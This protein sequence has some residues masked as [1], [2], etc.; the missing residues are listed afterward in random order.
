[1]NKIYGFCQFRAHPSTVHPLPVEPFPL[2]AGAPSDGDSVPAR[3]EE[4]FATMDDAPQPDQTAS[5]GRPGL[6]VL[7]RVPAARYIL[8][9]AHGASRNGM[10]VTR[11]Q[12]CADE[13]PIVAV[14]VRKGHQLSPLIRDSAHFGLAEL[15][16]S[17]RLLAR[18]FESPVDLHGEDPFLGHRLLPESLTRGLPIPAGVAAWISCE[19]V[20]H[21]DIE[22]DHELY[23]GRVVAGAVIE[24]PHVIANGVTAG[25][26]IAPV[27]P[28][29]DGHA[30]LPVNGHG[31]PRHDRASA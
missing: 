22:A 9:A 24:V 12:H 1:L 27:R 19:L 30:A 31:H 13:P 15:R 20:R 2:V 28:G 5:E 8:S 23:V 6:E 25:N 29:T 7:R 11:I 10:V 4:D 26:G 17:E 3:K 21:L 16:A 14:S 18:K